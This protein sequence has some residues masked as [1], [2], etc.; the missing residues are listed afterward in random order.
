MFPKK[1][2]VVDKKLLN[3]FHGKPC[4]ICGS[5]IGT[6]GHHIQTRGARGDDSEENLIAVCQFHHNE[7]HSKG[8]ET[9]R[10]K[11]GR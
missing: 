5:T 11:Y 4:V 7:I 1:K 8:R 2:R 9:F 3:S 10:K 6:V